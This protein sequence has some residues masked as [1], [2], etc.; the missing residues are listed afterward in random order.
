MKVEKLY[1]ETTHTIAYSYN[2]TLKTYPNGEQKIKYHTYNNLKGIYRN[3]KGSG[4]G[5]DDYQKYKNLVKTKQTLI[6]LAYCNS[7]V[8]PWEYFVTLTFD[9]NKVNANDYKSVTE[10]LSKWLDNMKH[11]NKNMQYL[12]APE[13]HPTSGR[14]HFHGIFKN[15]P[16]WNLEEAINP[17]TGRKI[18]KNGLQIYNLTN[19]KYGHTTVS[20]ITNQE[21][22]SVYMAKYMTKELIDLAYKK[23]YWSSKGLLKPTI[24]YAQMTEDHLKFYIDINRVDEFYQN[25]KTISFTVR[26]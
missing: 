11:Q 24:E 5:S 9:D 6:D 14:I 13:P 18:K 21:A 8:S 10:A 3:R 22:V 4:V 12:L 2:T 1:N 19:Y 25:D 26:S 20:K 16:K 7:I 15:V 23:R 17:H